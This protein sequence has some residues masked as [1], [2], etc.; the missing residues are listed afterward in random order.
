MALATKC[1][2]CGTT[3]RVASDQLKLRGGIVRCGTCQ[4]VFDGNASLVDLDQLATPA[5][6]AAPSHD[7]QHAPAPD[8]NAMPEQAAPAGGDDVP[9]YTL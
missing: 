8:T 7:A 5:P 1:P 6:S 2:H 9:V 3:F 4:Q